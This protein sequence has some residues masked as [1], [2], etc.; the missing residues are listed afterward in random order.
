M[1]QDVYQEVSQQVEQA[2]RYLMRALS[3]VQ[4]AR[5]GRS[6]QASDARSLERF[7]ERSLG[8]LRQIPRVEMEVETDDPDLMTEDQLAQRFRQ[9]RESERVA[10]TKARQ[11][12][13]EFAEREAE[14][15]L[16]EEERLM[17]EVIDGEVDS[18]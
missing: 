17:A 13:R 3:S 5:R 14:A 6:L 1:S 7:L 9:R 8:G 15:R 10:R 2:R 4:R 12:A 16:R 11:E 18:E